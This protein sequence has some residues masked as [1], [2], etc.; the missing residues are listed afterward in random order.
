MTHIATTVD[1]CFCIVSDSMAKEKLIQMCKD[2]FQEITV[3]E[4]DSLNIIGMNFQFDRTSKTVIVQQKQFVKELVEKFGVTR[5]AA[6]PALVD[7]YDVDEDSPLLKDQLN[8]MSINS[9]CMYAGKRTYPEVLPAATYLA[10]KYWKATEED[11]VKVL[12]IV[13]YLNYDIEG[14]CLRLCPTSF[15]IVASSDA[16]YGEHDDGRSQTGGCVGLQGEGRGSFFIFIS[17]KQPVVAKSSCEA[18]LISGSTVGDYLLWLRYMILQLGYG[19]QSAILEQDNLSAIGFSQ[20]GRGSFK[21]S[22]HIKV[23][24]FW[25]KGLIDEGIL[26]LKYVPSKKMVADILTKPVVGAQFKYLL[27]MLLGL[28]WE[29][30]V[31]SDK[32]TAAER[33]VKD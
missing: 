26:L 16:S 2:T 33:G 21:R 18:E 15:A 22:K 4:G 27:K 12:R 24:Y 19:E 1:D 13:E 3:E 7:L 6:T 17:S 32:H 11:L 30:V 8:Y 28:E 31:K 20:K 5:A 14:H 9:S 23:R 10:S 29:S 25:L